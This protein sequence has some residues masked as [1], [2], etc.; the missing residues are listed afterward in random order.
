[1]LLIIPIIKVIIDY[2]TN[3]VTIDKLGVHFKKGLINIKTK[4]FNFDGIESV[5]ID[6]SVFGLIFN[7][8]DIKIIGKGHTSA[9]FKKI[10]NPQKFK[11]KLCEFKE[12]FSS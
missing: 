2:Y 4:D 7:Y 3:I 8:G 12:K 10:E 9:T 5:N 6:Q 1:M 11:A